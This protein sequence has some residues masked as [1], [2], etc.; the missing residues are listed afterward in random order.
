MVYYPTSVEWK[1]QWKIVPETK[2]LEKFFSAHTSSNELK[3]RTLFNSQPPVIHSVT[4]ALY[5]ISSV[6]SLIIKNI[7]KP[8]FWTTVP[9]SRYFCQ[10]VFSGEY[11]YFLPI[12]AWKYSYKCSKKYGV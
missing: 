10:Y 11:L 5:E 2:K 12:L 6:D 7:W 9:V 4:M 3:H 1:L 8:G